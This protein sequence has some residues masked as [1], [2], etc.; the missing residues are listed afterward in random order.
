M[1][2]TMDVVL[3]NGDMYFHQTELQEEHSNEVQ[4]FS[5][6]CG[7]KDKIIQVKV[8][9]LPLLTLQ[10]LSQ[11]SS[12]LTSSSHPSLPPISSSPSST[13]PSLD[14]IN[15]LPPRKQLPNRTN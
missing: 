13:L 8:S 11:P 9:S 2:M 15:Q 5:F 7:N 4:S 3:H 14:T 1:H 10:L 12:P 6:D